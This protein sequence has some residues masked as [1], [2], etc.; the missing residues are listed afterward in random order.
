MKAA[1]AVS[2]RARG[3]RHNALTRPCERYGVLETCRRSRS[4]IG[5][6]CGSIAALGDCSGGMASEQGVSCIM[7][8]EGIVELGGTCC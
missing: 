6:S 8:C 5:A 7:D 1:R 4:S 3:M 2:G